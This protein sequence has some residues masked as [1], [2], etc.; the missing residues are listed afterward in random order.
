[1]AEGRSG[2]LPQWMPPTVLPKDVLGTGVPQAWDAAQ[3]TPKLQVVKS[4]VL[5]SRTHFLIRLSGMSQQ[6]AHN[7][8][9]LQVFL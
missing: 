6:F 9:I 1:M 7:T 8:D 4:R 3:R 2:R 5:I